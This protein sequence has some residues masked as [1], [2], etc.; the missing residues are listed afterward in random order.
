MFVP[1]IVI[2]LSGIMMCFWR[3]IVGQRPVLEMARYI[4]YPDA[5]MTEINFN[6]QSMHSAYC[7]RDFREFLFNFADNM[8]SACF[9]Y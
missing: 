4:Q 5:F 2:S 6:I 7:Q 8:Q 3:P 1:D 9:E